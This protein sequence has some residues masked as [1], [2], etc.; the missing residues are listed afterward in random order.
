MKKLIAVLIILVISS[1]SY[2]MSPETKKLLLGLG[3]VIVGGLMQV[4][5]TQKVKYSDAEYKY[6]TYNC[7]TIEDDGS[8]TIQQITEKVEVHPAL[9]KNQSDTLIYGGFFIMAAGSFISLTYNEGTVYA[10]KS[11][12][13]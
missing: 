12:K 2:A 9:Y 8:C 5:G 6:D 3:M 11:I 1:N 10:R 7:M 4:Q 13:F